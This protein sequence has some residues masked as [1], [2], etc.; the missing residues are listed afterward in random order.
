[1]TQTQGCSDQ[2]R[3][4]RWSHFYFGA[5]A[6]QNTSQTFYVKTNT[7]QIIRSVYSLYIHGPLLPL[8]YSLPSC[9]PVTIYSHLSDEM[10]CS[11][12]LMKASC[13]PLLLVAFQA[14]VLPPPSFLHVFQDK[15]THLPDVGCL[16]QRSLLL[17]TMEGGAHTHPPPKAKERWLDRK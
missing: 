12:V 1:M 17:M 6:T 8:A 4:F 14:S 13:S 7:L 15:I 10:F 16:A 2:P 5:S 9:T 3:C 11:G